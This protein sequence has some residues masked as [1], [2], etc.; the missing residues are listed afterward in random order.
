[1]IQTLL[2]FINCQNQQLITLD[3]SNHDANRSGF[4]GSRP[5][6]DI[7]SSAWILRE[8]LVNRARENRRLDIQYVEVVVIHFVA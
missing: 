5:D 1:M 7:A 4:V 6:D 3:E 8:S 2:D